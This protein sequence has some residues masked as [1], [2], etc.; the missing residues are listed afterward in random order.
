MI[1]AVTTDYNRKTIDTCCCCGRNGGVGR[2][3]K[4]GKSVVDGNPETRYKTNAKHSCSFIVVLHS[5]ASL[6]CVE[7]IIMTE[8]GIE[9]KQDGKINVS[10]SLIII[11][12]FELHINSMIIFHQPHGINDLSI[13]W[14]I[15]IQLF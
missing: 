7:I 15:R 1:T 6:L 4:Q 3:E 14:V 13:L 5:H 12:A 9:D 11:L 10:H 2:G 8:E